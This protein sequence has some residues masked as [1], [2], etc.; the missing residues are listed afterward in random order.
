[1][2]LS[3]RIICRPEIAPGFGLAGV[4]IDLATDA[5]AARE[6]LMAFA[7]DPTVGIVLIDEPLHRALPTDVVQRLERQA[8][9]IVATFPGPRFDAK[10]AAEAAL[11]EIL[12]RAIGYRVRLP[13]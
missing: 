4:R 13:T 11:L 8:R 1:M 10:G 5:A 2:D 6:R 3:V 12:Q 7:G 9:P